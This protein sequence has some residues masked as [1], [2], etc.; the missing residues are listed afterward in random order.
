MVQPGLA[1]VAALAL[2]ACPSP[3]VTPAP[4]P[5]AAAAAAQ[6][7]ARVVTLEPAARTAIIAGPAFVSSVNPGGDL[8]LALV[9]GDT[10][11][12]DETWFSYSGGGVAVPAGQILCARSRAD[13]RRVHAFSGR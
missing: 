4:T 6:P 1:V 5:V 8:E 12:G 9:T 11:G 3:P 10:C 13:V 7:Y 2:T